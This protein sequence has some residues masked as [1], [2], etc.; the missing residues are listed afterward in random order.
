MILNRELYRNS[1]GD[2]FSGLFSTSTSRANNANSIALQQEQIEN[3]KLIQDAYKTE[4][5][6]K[7]QSE[8]TTYATITVVAVVLVVLTIF[9]TRK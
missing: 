5:A 1:L 7:G 8:V 9:F 6:S 4:A 2:L 3:E